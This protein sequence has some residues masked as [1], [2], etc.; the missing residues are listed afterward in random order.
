MA[1]HAMPW[2]AMAWHGMACVA[3][4][5]AG[6]NTFPEN[7]NYVKKLICRNH[8]KKNRNKIWRKLVVER[9]HQ[10]CYGPGF[11]LFQFR[12]FLPRNS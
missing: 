11:G 4:G 7:R 8:A 2:H 6:G 1:C 3:G 12:L 10:L 9:P 5:R